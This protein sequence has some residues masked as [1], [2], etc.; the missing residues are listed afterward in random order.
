[1]TREEAERE[2]SRERPILWGYTEDKVHILFRELLI[3][4]RRARR[5]AEERVKELEGI[6]LAQFPKSEEEESMSI[7][8]KHLSDQ[9]YRINPAY[10]EYIEAANL[11]LNLSDAL[12]RT[13]ISVLESEVLRLKGEKIR[14]ENRVLAVEQA[15]T[16][17]NAKWFQENARL[18]EENEKLK[19]E[20][21]KGF[22]IG[23]EQ[24]ENHAYPDTPDEALATYLVSKKGE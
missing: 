21:K 14:L 1:M 23:V 2:L 9:D 17:G 15:M 11:V 24:G 3:T 5:L 8:K 10:A 7:P 6:D 20:F 16:D 22:E 19:E 4:E 12:L 13:D 18:R